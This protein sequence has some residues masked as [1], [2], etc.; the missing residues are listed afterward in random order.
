MDEFYDSATQYGPQD[1]EELPHSVNV[2]PYKGMDDYC[3]IVS[4]ER[5]RLYSSFRA[6]QDKKA[7]A[8]GGS[9]EGR[10]DDLTT[11]LQTDGTQSNHIIFIIEPL[12]FTH[13]FLDPED[14][15]FRDRLSFNP[16]TKILVVKMPVRA[17]EQ[18]TIAF[19]DM[20]K[21][22]LQPMQLHR[23]IGSWLSTT[24]TGADGTSKEA[25]GGWGPRRAPGGAAKRPWVILEVASSETSGKLRRDAHY[26]VDPAGGQAIIAIGVKVNG[27]IPKISIGKWEWDAQYSRPTQTFDV[28]ITKSDAGIHFEPDQPTPRLEIPYETLFRRPKEINREQDVVFAAQELIEFA[29]EVWEV[30]F[31]NE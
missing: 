9:C 8:T 31:E 25:N 5:N 12:T 28:T 19:D 4:S 15:P 6:A 10:Q 22:A 26:W 13:D 20:L 3:R 23:M 29:T 2:Y 1:M 21:L 7:E 24:L 11:L 27:K 14:H 17:H 16:K 18:A 30:Q